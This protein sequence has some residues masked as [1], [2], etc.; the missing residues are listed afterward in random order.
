MR[1]GG[2]KDEGEDLELALRAE[3]VEEAVRRSSAILNVTSEVG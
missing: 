2:G 3:V 1:E